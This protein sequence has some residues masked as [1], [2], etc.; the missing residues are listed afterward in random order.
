MV[1]PGL[2]QEARDIR[3][4]RVRYI[5]DSAQNIPE[6]GIAPVDLVFSAG[7]FDVELVGMGKIE[8]QTGT[9]AETYRDMVSGIKSVMSPETETLVTMGLI[10]NPTFELV[11]G[12]DP[13]LRTERLGDKKLQVFR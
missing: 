11:S 4:G 3:V 1:D 7:T 9:L 2:K 12:K 13:E 5:K 10:E 8:G 6:Y